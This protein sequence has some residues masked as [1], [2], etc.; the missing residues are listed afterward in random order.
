MI[1]SGYGKFFIDDDLS[2]MS[3]NCQNLC[4][5]HDF[6]GML[7]F[8][9]HIDLVRL[10]GNFVEYVCQTDRKDLV[11]LDS[12]YCL[13]FK[14]IEIIVWKPSKPPTLLAL[15]IEERIKGTRKIVG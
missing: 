6:S 11:L 9:C 10:W 14:Y 2:E 4:P 15:I 13:V 12:S 1:V 8:A 7:V 5:S 3:N